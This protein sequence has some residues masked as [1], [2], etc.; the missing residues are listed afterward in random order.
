MLKKC[1][2]LFFILSLAVSVFA[3]DRRKPVPI[4]GKNILPLR[5]LARPFSN[6]Y[7]SP[8]LKS[9]TVKENIPAFAPYY[10]YTRPSAEDI[11]L[12]DG[13]YE[14]GADNRGN[15]A[16]WMQAKDVF[17]WKQTMCLAYTHPE[18]RRPVLMFSSRTPL[19]DII[20]KDA[21]ARV[22][23]VNSI[24]TAIETKQIPDNFPVRSIEPKQAVDIS[25]QFYLLPILSFEELEIDG[26]EGRLLQ[27]AA[28]TAGGPNARESTDISQNKD[29]L[30][31][32]N[33]AAGDV[34]PNVLK[35]MKI[36]VVF[37]SDTTVS[38]RPYIKATLDV[39]KQVA[40]DLS[41]D[42]ATAR[43]LKFGVWGYRDP[44]DKIPD[45]GY[46]THN[47]TPQLLPADEF[48]QALSR[49][50]V[51]K[52]DSDDYA[53]DVFSGINDA[54]A[55]T[56]WED[57][58]IRVII[59]LGDAP[60]HETGHKYNASGQS[61]QTLRA[62]SDDASIYLYAIHVKAPRAQKYHEPARI[63]FSELSANPGM[64]GQSAYYSVSS[65][66]MPGFTQ[67]A[68]D[69]TSALT[70][71]LKNVKQ[72]NISKNLGTA[73]HLSEEAALSQPSPV[74]TINGD[75][76]ITANGHKGILH[77]EPGS[78]TLS[79]GGKLETM[80]D[81]SFDGSTL[82]F[83]RPIPCCTQVY[84]GKLQAGPEGTQRFEGTFTQK[85]T[86]TVFKWNSDRDKPISQTAQAQPPADTPPAS[87]TPA[88][89][90]PTIKDDS[91]PSAQQLAYQMV[92]AAMVDWIG[93]QSGAQAPRDIVAWATDK[94]LTEPAIQ[95]M[96]VRLLVNKRQLD[97]L[98][99][100]LKEVM[101]AGRRGQIGG[102]DFFSALQATS[103]A[104]SRDPNLIKNAKSMAA[105]GLI[106]EFLS[107][108]PYKSSLMSMNNDLWMS[109]SVD[110][111][112]E[113][114]NELEAKM[115]AYQSIHDRP[116]GWIALSSEDDPDEHVYPVSLE[117]LP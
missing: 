34:A 103:A 80:T 3:E 109:W 113:F 14:V 25:T 60:G 12:Q 32:A 23:D 102:E 76:K 116:E 82:V 66:D 77:I 24:Y 62:I 95:S 53:E 105:T 104:A 57:G 31:T 110:E 43:S 72:G 71:M 73:G 65:E 27:I 26:R 51:T 2:W 4:E 101:A 28:A 16:G 89:V 45:I 70:L 33:Q 41:S 87:E 115:Q 15:I 117:L 84:T 94:D 22:S 54:I 97:S 17:E 79:L 55:Q 99:T 42:P 30:N 92:K 38:M 85:G 61:A 108:L 91:N 44:V 37:V 59:L 46:T 111:Q 10:V 40:K 83:T 69:I 67:V 29:Y 88:T 64:Q 86:T 21:Q 74:E 1:F 5:V 20:Q 49:V 48:V 52:I 98:N 107:G 90:S 36:D 56:A 7:N 112:D 81:M 93:K 47:Y 18:G 19:S 50:D 13:W 58:A 6:I 39:I 75:W 100:I 78:T 11:E 9:A 106:P 114:L 35:D 8:D 63:Q 68:S 96:E